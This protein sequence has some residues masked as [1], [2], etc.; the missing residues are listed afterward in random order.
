M[1]GA[2]PPYNCWPCRSRHFNP[3]SPCGER[4][5]LLQH[6][7]DHFFI[8]IHA[9]RVGSDPRR[10]LHG[11]EYRISIHAPR[12]GSDALHWR[13]FFIFLLFQSTLPVWGATALFGVLG[14]C[15]GYFNPRSPCGERRGRT[16][17][18]TVLNPPFQSTLPVW[19][20]TGR[21]AGRCR[22][23]LRFQSTLPVWGAT[24]RMRRSLKAVEFQSTLPVWG[25]THRI[26]AGLVDLAISIHAPRVGSDGT[27]S[28][29]QRQNRGFQ[30]TL[31][32][33]GATTK[34]PDEINKAVFQS[35]LPVWGATR[36]SHW[37]RMERQFQSTLPVW[38]ATRS[39][40]RPLT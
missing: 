18:G 31:P 7:H 26:T 23:H 27:G 38:G 15:G 36:H 3:R 4:L 28:P 34:D 29:C 8:S 12:V 2:T 1:W 25:A 33:W 6:E 39:I 5:H 24:Q 40:K 37:P 20:A 32:V 30:S 9:P 13:V 21:D 35:T 16:R 19:G 14:I 17:T 11:E 10:S 22:R